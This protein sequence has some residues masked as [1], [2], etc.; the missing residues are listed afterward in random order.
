MDD[1]T[2]TRNRQVIWP[3]LRGLASGLATRRPEFRHHVVRDAWTLAK[4]FAASSVENI[5]AREI[6]FLRDAIVEGY[7][8]DPHRLLLA[9]LARGLGSRTFFEIG[10]NRGRTTW[11]VAHNNPELVLYTLDVPLGVEPAAAALT[12][13]EDDQ[14]FF[15][16]NAACGEAFR[17][18]PEAE[19]ITQLWG[20][21]ATFD[22]TPYVGAI[23]LVYVDGA[24]TYEY[25][26]SDSA[27][28]L[29]ML[30]DKGTVTWD[31]YTTN[32]GVYRCVTELARGLDRPV[33]HVFGTRMALYSRQDLVQ[34]LA[35]DHQT[36]L[37]TI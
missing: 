35:P 12:L 27:N 16:P 15:R 6:P 9:A 24:H 36:S 18:T 5:E 28:A 25:V 13:G 37:P 8:E 14:R 4:R 34:R 23:D 20:D 2:L 19:R 1:A 3:I 32:P 11:T 22:F 10:T 17:D 21:S 29:R 7:L 33:Y 26:A 31:D 30:S